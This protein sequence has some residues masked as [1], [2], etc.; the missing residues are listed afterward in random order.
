VASSCLKPVTFSD[1]RK[2]QKIQ[3]LR[4]FPTTNASFPP[5]KFAE[6]PSNLCGATLSRPSP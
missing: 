4:P 1:P 2:P 6:E 5:T 3:I